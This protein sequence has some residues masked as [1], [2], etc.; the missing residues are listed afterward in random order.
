MQ[1][2]KSYNYLMQTSNK[3]IAHL[4]RSVAATYLLQG[5]NRFRTIAYENAADTVEHLN[6]ELFELW[7]NGELHG[8]AGIGPSISAHLEEYFKKGDNSY[9]VR[10]INKIPGG[11]F[12]LMKVPGIGPKRSYK[13]VTQLKLKR[14]ET[15]ID[16]LLVA[17]ES[18][19]VAQLETFGDKSQQEIVRAID[20][21]KKVALREE[22]MPLP[23]A[24]KLAQEVIAYLK[25]SPAV[26]SV[27]ALG[28]LRRWVATIG[29]IDLAAIC[30]PGKSS[31]VIDRF[32]N[33]PGRVKTEGVGEKKASILLANGRRIDLRVADK[34]S[35][36]A[37]LQ[38]FTGS[39]AHNVKLRD[40]AL[41]KGYSLSEYGIKRV[42]SSKHKAQND[43]LKLKINQFKTEEDFYKFLGL[44]FIAPEIRE[45]TNE[46]ELAIKKQLPN[47]V[48][49]KDI[50]GEF[51]VHSSYNIEPSHDLGRNSV[52]E[53]SY[54][55]KTLGYK[56]LGVA[57][58]NPSLINHTHDQIVAIMKRRYHAF[59]KVNTVIPIII[60][61]EVDILPEDGIA[62]P[63]GAL[64]FVDMIIVSIH[65]TFRQNKTT[66]TKRILRALS[67]PKVKILGHPT[68]RMM[69]RREEIDA[70]WPTIFAE[71]KKRNIA[72]E[73][74]SWPGRLDLPDILVRQAKAIRCQFAV[75]TDAH[76]IEEMDNMFYGISVA[77][78]GW[79][80]KNDIINARS[81]NEVKSW[82]E[83]V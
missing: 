77:R 4:L 47:I 76:Q 7:Q 28:S 65:S 1:F 45:G 75:D 2:A 79:L 64:S 24:H 16:D 78:R 36:G 8:L 23:Y 30:Q 68:G 11:V 66:M 29:D 18:G 26:I 80:E 34:A 9:L 49:R 52:V 72:L 83:E 58:H 60:S 81:Y 25:E 59:K 50:K 6:R 21:Y 53:M 33:F 41:N 48:E 62:L 35:Y 44:P 42:Q 51:H 32:I 17:C 82:I 22:R 46:I 67:Y 57:D 19:K 69:P 38:Y 10:T 14:A 73:I 27:E 13:L 40:Y 71:C 12:T 70:D 39:K 43:R 37:M 31:L 55:A 56:Y 3:E 5:K 54:R 20:L 74:N 61:C 15:V 63:D